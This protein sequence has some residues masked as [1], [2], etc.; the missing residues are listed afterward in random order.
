METMLGHPDLQGLRRVFL[1]T[2]DAH[3]LYERFGF[4]RAATASSASWRSR[5]SRP[6]CT[7]LRR[8]C[9]RVVLLAPLVA[10]VLATGCGGGKTKTTDGRRHA[11]RGADGHAPATSPATTPSTTGTAPAPVPSGPRSCGRI[12]ISYPNGEG[13]SSAV[14]IVATGLGCGEARAVTRACQRGNLTPGWNARR[15]GGGILMTSGSR[16]IT[17]RLAG[18][19]GCLP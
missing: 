15:G 3:G 4:Q 10:L 9:G 2:A 18:G 5:A 16:R 6:S 17:F 8:S 1:V 12:E 14:G 19:G 13:G 11:D 7:S